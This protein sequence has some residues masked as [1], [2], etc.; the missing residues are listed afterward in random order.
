MPAAPVIV[1]LLGFPLRDKAQCI[2]DIA[3]PEAGAVL[4]NKLGTSRQAWRISF[5]KV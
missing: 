5:N 2:E 4:G 1:T 3:A